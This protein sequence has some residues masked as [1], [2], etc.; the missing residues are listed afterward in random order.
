MSNALRFHHQKCI[1]E[2]R[3]RRMDLAKDALSA[4]GSEF[5]EIEREIKAINKDLAYRK[6]AIKKLGFVPVLTL[7]TIR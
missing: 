2:G 7:P 5:K 1:D 3:V 6:R 4:S